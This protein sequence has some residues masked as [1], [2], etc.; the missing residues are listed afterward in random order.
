[1][2]LGVVQARIGSTR[3][4]AKALLP[5]GDTT[6]VGYAIETIWD[7]KTD[8]AVLCTPDEILGEFVINDKYLVWCGERSVTSELKLAT[9]KYKAD[10]IVR[11]TADCPFVT[12]E[13]INEVLEAHLKTGADYTFNHHDLFESVTPEGIDVEVVSKKLLKQC[14]SREHLITSLEGV[15]YTRVDMEEEREVFSV[16]TLE[17]YVRAYTLIRG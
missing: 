15:K 13:I 11:I 3:L 16:N 7:S 9:I 5:M 2:I 14:C 4:P 10:H 6:M 12:P 8:D 1:M 17:E